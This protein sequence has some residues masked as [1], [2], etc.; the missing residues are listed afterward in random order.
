MDIRDWPGLDLVIGPKSIVPPGVAYNLTREELEKRIEEFIPISNLAPL[1]K[2][3]VK[4]FHVHGDNDQVV[5][6][7]PNSLEAQKRY[8][9]LGG[10]FELEV[11]KGGGHDS[12]PPF[13]QCKRGLEFLLED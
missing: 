12:F 6:L 1:A 4:I 9:T 7:E 8:Q 11:V 3:G 10:S 5:H 13:Y 2:A